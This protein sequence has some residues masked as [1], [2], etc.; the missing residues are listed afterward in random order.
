MTDSAG[1]IRVGDK[2]ISATMSQRKIHKLLFAMATLTIS[3][4]SAD[5]DEPFP[6]YK[7]NI[8]IPSM[9]EA[10][11]NIDGTVV[12]T[13]TNP[14]LAVLPGRDYKFDIHGVPIDVLDPVA[15]EKVGESSH[16]S[17][18]PQE[19]HP[20]H[21]KGTTTLTPSSKV[22]ASDD[23]FYCLNKVYPN[24]EILAD[25]G[26][27]QCEFH[28]T[29]GFSILWPHADVVQRNG[30]QFQVAKMSP[31]RSIDTKSMGL[32]IQVP[33]DFKP[34]E[35]YIAFLGSVLDHFV[36]RF[37]GL[38]SSTLQVG[39]I[40]RGKDTEVNGS[41]SG[42][43][44]LFSRTA[45]GAP[46]NESSSHPF[47]STLDLSDALRRLV[48]AHEISHLWFGDKFLG[49][50]GWMVEGIP[51][52]LGLVET[53]KTVDKAHGEAL[54]LFFQKI[55]KTGSQKPIPSADLSTQDGVILSNYSAPLALYAI[56]EKVGH[57]ALISLIQDVYD[58]KNKPAFAD[59]ETAFK[60]KFPQLADDWTRQWQ[61]QTPAPTSK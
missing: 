14:A 18:P 31:I 21:F 36:D 6:K 59:F 19:H 27:Y 25:G 49:D 46:L 26:F 4:T 40:K 37:G 61:L 52:Y 58:K 32:Q 38:S 34:D 23:E 3:A 2:T 53:I 7:L 9:K 42:D 57:D 20:V 16:P 11:L 54:L 29:P 35:K 12:Y 1:L 44:I 50:E 13:N 56:G 48:I 33:V 5:A 60:S 51:Q 47:G 15:P 8:T 55:A 10:V 24:P 22:M 28:V 39:A 43:L 41:P 30:L 45:L 17:K